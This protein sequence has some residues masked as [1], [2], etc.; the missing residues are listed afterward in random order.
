MGR[1][2]PT[3]WC[4]TLDPQVAMSGRSATNRRPRMTLAPS[5]STNVDFD[6]YQFPGVVPVATALSAAS[7]IDVDGATDVSVSPIRIAGRALRRRDVGQ[8]VF[9]DL[10][11]Q[12]GVI[13]VM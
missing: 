8:L 4:Y 7:C 11:D 10:A 13:Q 9:L 5:V 3:L 2:C 6:T 1:P 12:S